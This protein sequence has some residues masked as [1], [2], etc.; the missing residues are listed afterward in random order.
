MTWRAFLLAATCAALFSCADDESTDG[1]GGD[2]CLDPTGDDHEALQTLL[3]EVKSGEV[4]V[5][6]EGT[7]GLT[8]E[9][10]LSVTGVTVRG[11][12]RDKTVLDFTGQEFGAQAVSITGN[13]TVLES[14][15][16][17]NAGGDGI[18]VSDV[19]GITFRE[20]G[21][22]WTEEHATSNGPYGLYPV[23][24][25]NVLIDRCYVKGASDAGIYVGQSTN[26]V[27]RHSEATGNVAGIE[28]ENSV[29]ADVHDNH[30][31]GNTG[32]ILI[33]NL[34][35]LPMQGG[36]RAKVHDNIVENNNVPNFGEEGSVVGLVP[37]GIGLILL[38]AD[39]NEVTANTI[40]N[41]ESTGILVI[42]YQDSIF[43]EF[44]DSNF[45]A[46]AEG[47]HIHGNTFADNGAAPQGALEDL[48]LPV[49]LADILWE[50]CLGDPP[51]EETVGMCIHDNGDA[52]FLNFRFCNGLADQVTDTTA[53]ECTHDPL[54]A[55]DL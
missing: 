29:D 10:S 34:P 5:L 45:D 46:Y 17:K 3:I 16:V 47:N 41:N 38:A 6:G 8:E 18:R 27:V 9:I 31:H 51:R 13:D 37:G 21:V 15:T 2:H 44:T 43:G 11:A 28:I 55:V 22:V 25:S 32:G 53:F 19:D 24:S 33:F 49:P 20:V 39:D 4:I 52:R 42:S 26:I 48:G 1:C 23:S 36:A 30:A 54:P 14:F 50:G 12:G 7:F 35:E 40:R